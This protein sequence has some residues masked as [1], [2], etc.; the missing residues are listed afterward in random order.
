MATVKFISV[1]LKQNRSLKALNSYPRLQDK[2]SIATISHDMSK[3]NYDHV[4]LQLCQVLCQREIIIGSS[5]QLIRIIRPSFIGSQ[6]HNTRWS[7]QDLNPRPFSNLLKT[8]DYIFDLWVH[9]SKISWP[10]IE[11]SYA[12]WSKTGKTPELA[13]ICYKFFKNHKN[14]FHKLV[15][16]H[17]VCNPKTNKLALSWNSVMTPVIYLNTF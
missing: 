1:L 5:Y 17:F 9:D 2:W 10:S 12:K 16:T 11:K 7:Q 8:Y 14:V 6:E 4:F 3:K 13:I 15:L